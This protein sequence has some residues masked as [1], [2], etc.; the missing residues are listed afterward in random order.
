MIFNYELDFFYYYAFVC[1][2]KP[3]LWWWAQSVR[4]WIT[5]GIKVNLI[6]YLISV[7]EER[8]DP[9]KGKRLISFC[10]SFSR[11]VHEVC[12]KSF[13]LCLEPSWSG[14][15]VKHPGIKTLLYFFCFIFF[16]ISSVNYSLN[17]L[18]GHLV[19]TVYTFCHWPFSRAAVGLYRRRRWQGQGDCRCGGG[20]HSGS[21]TSRHHLLA[22]HEEQVFNSIH[23]TFIQIN[24]ISSKRC[25][26]AA[27]WKSGCRFRF[28]KWCENEKRNQALKGILLLL[29]DT[30]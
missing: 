20:S 4:F 10:W 18:F 14:R 25:Y 9:F 12:W 6:S 11:I 16:I 24:A 5:V 29:G 27:S 2:L 3:R 17:L 30:D 22:V 1:F 26:T 28:L 23:F 8:K 15:G 21:R 13:S 19:A 7:Q